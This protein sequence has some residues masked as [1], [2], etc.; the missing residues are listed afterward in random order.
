MVPCPGLMQ[1]AVPGN[2]QGWDPPTAP[3]IGSPA[4]S[5]AFEGYMFLNGGFKFVAANEQFQYVWGNTQYGDDGTFSG[6]LKM[7]PGETDCTTEPGYYRVRANTQTMTYSLQPIATWGII[8]AATPGGWDVSTPLTYNTQSQKWEATMALT[9]GEFKFR[10]NNTWDINLG[11]DGAAPE[12][13]TYDGNNLVI[14][15]A[16]TYL[17][18]LDFTHANYYTY[19]ATLQ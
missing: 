15:I 7:S 4:N 5:Q 2:H 8:G 18:S 6:V 16:G 9:V 3:R 10:A 13:L 1:M 11:Q 14:D 12:L 19:T 17:I